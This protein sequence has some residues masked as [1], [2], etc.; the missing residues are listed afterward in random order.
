VLTNNDRFYVV[1]DAALGIEVPK[2]YERLFRASPTGNLVNIETAAGD[3]AWAIKALRDDP[4]PLFAAADRGGERPRPELREPAVSLPAMTDG[5]EVVE[6]YRS[7]GLSLRAHPLAFLRGDLASKGFA[8]CADLKRTTAGRRI[9]V[10]GLVLV[11]QMPGSANGVMFI[12]LEDETGIGNL[13][14][15]PSVFEKFRRAILGSSMLG[16]A[17]AR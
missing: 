11:R 15:W 1:D 4:M 13:I 2:G 17:R 16:C 10:A 8:P 3:A 14:V 6:D 9:L 5:R 7:K 12:T